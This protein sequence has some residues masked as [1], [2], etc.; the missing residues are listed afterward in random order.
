MPNSSD[1]RLSD[2]LSDALTGDEVSEI[3]DGGT[4]LVS[5]NLPPEDVFR[6]AEAAGALLQGLAKADYLQDEEVSRRG[7]ELFM[8]VCDLAERK[9]FTSVNEIQKGIIQEWIDKQGGKKGG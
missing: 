6:A 8:R 1:D 5:L 2:L 4:E 3:L 9:T 7:R